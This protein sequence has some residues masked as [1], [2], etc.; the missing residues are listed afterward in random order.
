MQRTEEPMRTAL[1]VAAAGF[2]GAAA[3]FGIDGWF[4]GLAG[5]Q[6]TFLPWATLAVNLSGSW[7]LGLLVGSAARLG[8][9]PWL[10]EAAGTGFLGAFTTFSAFSIQMVAMFEAGNYSAAA[11]YAALNGG[12]GWLLAAWGL[13]WGRGRR[14]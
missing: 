11:L 2:L 12:A 9:P 5:G 3:R 4:A 13:R 14:A 10:Q 7:L 6:G 1:S 8:L